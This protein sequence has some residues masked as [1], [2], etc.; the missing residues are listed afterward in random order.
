MT[1]FSQICSDSFLRSMILSPVDFFPIVLDLLTKNVFSCTGLLIVDAQCFRI[2]SNLG[3]VQNFFSFAVHLIEYNDT[4]RFVSSLDVSH[5]HP[6]VPNLNGINGLLLM[7][8]YCDQRSC[9][10]LEMAVEVVTTGVITSPFHST[11]ISRV[12]ETILCQGSSFN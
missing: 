11:V 4:E 8:L 1:Q 9:Q 5:A 2:E 12:S 3:G 6:I 10:R 7:L